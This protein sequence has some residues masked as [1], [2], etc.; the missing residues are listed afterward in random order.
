MLSTAP[1]QAKPEMEMEGDLDLRCPCPSPPP[2][3]LLAST[4]AFVHTS[5]VM[6]PSPPAFGAHVPYPRLQ[7]SSSPPRLMGESDEDL[8]SESG[9]GDTAE[10]SDSPDGDFLPN[11]TSR[12][13]TRSRRTSSVGV[14]SGSGSGCPTQPC[15]L[16]APVPLPN[17]AQNCHAR[18]V[19]TTPV[20]GGVQKTCG[21]TS[22]LST[23]VTSLRSRRTFE[24][25]C[26]IDPYH[27]E[28]C[29]C[30]FAFVRASG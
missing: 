2:H 7:G 1:Q 24:V 4:P 5:G 8:G 16:S 22:A 19:P 30:F 28:A 3:G 6:S 14:S 11:R 26:V 15:R 25:T 29:V 10:L 13:R 23:D 17:I 27:R 9:E 18:R 20:Q 12:S 21:C